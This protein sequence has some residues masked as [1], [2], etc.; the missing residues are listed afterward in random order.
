MAS[1]EILLITNICIWVVINGATEGMNRDHILAVRLFYALV[2]SA[3]A[4]I[5]VF[6][7]NRHKYFVRACSQTQTGIRRKAGRASSSSSYLDL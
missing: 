5:E 2:S 6:S 7:L 3:C 1:V 4:V